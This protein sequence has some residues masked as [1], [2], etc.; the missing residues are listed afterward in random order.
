MAVGFCLQVTEE[1]LREFFAKEG[2]VGWGPDV[3]DGLSMRWWGLPT[4]GK[5]ATG[6]E[7]MSCWPRIVKS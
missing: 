6:F 3:V 5:L 1:D 7:P 2:E 4:F